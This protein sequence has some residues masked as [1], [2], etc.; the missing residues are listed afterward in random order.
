MTPKRMTPPE[1]SPEFCLAIILAVMAVILPGCEWNARE[2]RLEILQ[3]QIDQLSAEHKEASHDRKAEID[4][5]I[6]S[7]QVEQGRTIERPTATSETV[8]TLSP[9]V[10][11]GGSAAGLIVLLLLRR[12]DEANRERLRLKFET[13][14]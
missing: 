14:A 8:R 9:L 4:R 11:G 6:T 10:P 2:A 12:L 7:L 5:E 3:R 13:Q 1:R